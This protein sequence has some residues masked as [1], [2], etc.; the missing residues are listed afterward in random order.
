LSGLALVAVGNIV[1]VERREVIDEDEL[2]QRSFLLEAVVILDICL[3][4]LDADIGDEGVRP[5]SWA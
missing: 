1:S 3:A 5:P 4:A 2:G